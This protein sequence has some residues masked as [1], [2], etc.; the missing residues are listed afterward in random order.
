MLDVTDG[1][2]G[3]QHDAAVN[4]LD[5]F[6]VEAAEISQTE[7]S[8]ATQKRNKIIRYANKTTQLAGRSATLLVYD[9]R[10]DRSVSKR[11]SRTKKL[12]R[13]SSVWGNYA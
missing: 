11:M 7:H 8:L 13:K 9:V 3:Y 5:R 1:C 6:V 10:D 2:Y 12:V 4:V